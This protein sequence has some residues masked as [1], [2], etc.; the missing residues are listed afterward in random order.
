MPSGRGFAAGAE[1]KEDCW[2]L[3]RSGSRCFWQEQ[4]FDIQHVNAVLLDPTRWRRRGRLAMAE[5][6]WVKKPGGVSICGR[7]LGNGSCDYCNRNAQV[8][9]GVPRLREI[10]ASFLPPGLND[11]GLADFDG[12]ARF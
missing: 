7:N 3:L 10:E 1:G 2:C 5:V 9:L 4:G 11:A 12:F 8:L 6:A